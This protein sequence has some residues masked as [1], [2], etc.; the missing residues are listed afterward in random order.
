VTAEPFA[1]FFLG[2]LSP[3]FFGETAADILLLAPAG[4]RERV[5]GRLLGRRVVAGLVAV[6]VGLCARGPDDVKLCGM[7]GERFDAAARVRNVQVL[8][9]L[10]SIVRV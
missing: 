10:R 1:E 6:G 3:E 9:G 4:L 2:G 8:S 5:A 7:S